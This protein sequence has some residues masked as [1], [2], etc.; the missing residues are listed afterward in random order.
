MAKLNPPILTRGPVTGKVYVITHGKV[1]PHPTIPER[2]MVTASV[3][4]DVTEQFEEL[5][6]QTREADRSGQ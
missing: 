4:Y 5:V 3:K 1:E 2:T 6:A